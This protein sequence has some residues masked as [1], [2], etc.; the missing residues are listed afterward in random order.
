[1]TVKPRLAQ[2]VTQINLPSRPDAQLPG[3]KD[4]KSHMDPA[5]SKAPREAGQG[6]WASGSRQHWGRKSLG[7]AELAKEE[8][9]SEP[10]ARGGSG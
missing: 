10:Q 9:L 8:G 3:G 4:Q 6:R 7:S 5:Q 1:M 2:T